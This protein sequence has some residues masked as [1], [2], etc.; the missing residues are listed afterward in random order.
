[1][2]SIENNRHIKVGLHLAKNSHELRKEDIALVEIDVHAQ[3]RKFQ[4]TKF[5][6]I[7]RDSYN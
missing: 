6:S 7:S 1:M 5:S 2:T 4:L 3:L